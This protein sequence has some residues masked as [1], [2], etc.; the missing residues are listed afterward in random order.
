[1]S[2]ISASG[3]KRHCRHD[4]VLEK[5]RE[6]PA[7][8]EAAA[9]EGT[10][11]GK[12]VQDWLEGREPQE[13]AEKDD[14][15]HWYTNMRASWPPPPGV[16]CEVPLGLN[17]RG[18]FVEVL[19]P[20]PHVYIACTGERLVTAGRA[21]LAWTTSLGGSVGFVGDLKRSA[22]R[23]GYPGQHPQL[24]ALGL[25]WAAKTRVQWLF[26][27]LYDARDVTWDWSTPIDV[28]ED[29]PAM[30]AEV[31]EMAAMDSEPHPGPWCAGCWE[32]KACKAAAEGEAS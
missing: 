6:K 21:D 7:S 3:L 31:R 14:P 12:L 9:A 16:Q 22:W 5:L 20:D 15:W 2:L 11:F 8:V 28:A 13:P 30:L 18:E 23:Y 19:E 4:K 29:G 10:R 1:M 26:L 27:G 25:A 32:R 24:M 17:H